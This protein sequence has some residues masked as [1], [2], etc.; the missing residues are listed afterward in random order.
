[1]FRNRLID[2]YLHTASRRIIDVPGAEGTGTLCIG[3]NALRKQEVRMG[4][5]NNQHFVSVPRVRFLD[6][7]RY[8]AELV[9]MRVI[10]T[11][12]SYTSQ[13]SFLDADPLP[14]YD[15]ARSDQ[16]RFSGR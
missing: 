3:Q 4:K 12:E 6:L 16:L 11:E 15:A 10:V 1:M 13:A 8:K 9:G 7:L 5:R 14:V 2:W